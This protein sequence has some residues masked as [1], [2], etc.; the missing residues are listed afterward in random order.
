MA[1]FNEPI[2]PMM[3][4][5]FFEVPIWPEANIRLATDQDDVHLL[6]AVTDEQDYER[7]L[8]RMGRACRRGGGGPGS[9]GQRGDADA[10]GLDRH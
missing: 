5:N 4:S 1:R 9:R 2:E 10:G 7:A 6:K 8:H 3:L